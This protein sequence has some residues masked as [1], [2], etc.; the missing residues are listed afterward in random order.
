MFTPKK[1]ISDTFDQY[2]HL[3]QY[4]NNFSVLCAVHTLFYVA[5][6]VPT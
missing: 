3:L 4:K 1:Q 2:R 5:C 6:V